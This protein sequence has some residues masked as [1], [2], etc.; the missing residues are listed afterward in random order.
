MTPE[1][2]C[3]PDYSYEKGRYVHNADCPGHDDLSEINEKGGPMSDMKG[4][5]TQKNVETYLA[6]MARWE[7]VPKWRLP[8]WLEA[9]PHHVWYGHEAHDL[10]EAIKEIDRDEASRGIRHKRRRRNFWRLP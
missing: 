9:N 10:S 1:P 4:E 5:E 7:R 8:N 2:C 6:Y 3:D